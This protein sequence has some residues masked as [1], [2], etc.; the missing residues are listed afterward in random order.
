MCEQLLSGHVELEYTAQ[1]FLLTICWVMLLVIA[2]DSNSGAMAQWLRALP[3][4][5][6]DMCVCPRI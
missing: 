6:K 1:T 4:L 2:R 5:S 3:T